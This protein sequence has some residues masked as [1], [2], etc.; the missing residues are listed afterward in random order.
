MIWWACLS[1]YMQQN[2]LQY[3]L[4]TPVLSRDPAQSTNA[5]LIGVAPSDG[6]TRWPPVGPEA[7]IRRSNSSE[8]MTLS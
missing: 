2:R 7:Q 5:I 4:P 1:E 8:E 6:R 3:G